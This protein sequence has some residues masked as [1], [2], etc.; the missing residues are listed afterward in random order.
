ML[1]DAQQKKAARAR[2]IRYPPRIPQVFVIV[3]PCLV[4]NE[5]V[6]H[7]PAGTGS[8]PVRHE[9]RGSPASS[10]VKAQIS[11]LGPLALAGDLPGSGAGAVGSS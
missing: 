7:G 3:C 1:H 6:T 5:V 2:I 9:P 8:E 11:L 4:L 10:A